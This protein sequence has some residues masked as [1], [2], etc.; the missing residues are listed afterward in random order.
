MTDVS[1]ST[2]SS[3]FQIPGEAE[4]YANALGIVLVN[5]KG[6]YQRAAG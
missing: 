1:F 2:V 4:E 5:G 3:L 6:N